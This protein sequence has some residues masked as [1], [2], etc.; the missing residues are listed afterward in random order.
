LM[1]DGMRGTKDIAE[2]L[3]LSRGYVSKLKKKISQ[4]CAA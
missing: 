3:G 2:E 4:E 1:E